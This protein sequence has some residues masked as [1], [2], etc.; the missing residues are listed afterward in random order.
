L[1]T[2][3]QAGDFDAQP[4]H[5]GFHASGQKLLIPW[6]R[7]ELNPQRTTRAKSVHRVLMNIGF[8]TALLEMRRKIT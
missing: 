3:L 7:C 4:E 5:L 1:C 2:I 8:E 6:V